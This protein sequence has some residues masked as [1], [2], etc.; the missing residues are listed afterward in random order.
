MQVRCVFGVASSVCLCA[1]ALATDPWA[2][3]VVSYT[4]GAGVGAGYDAPSTALGQPA[5]FTGVGVFPGAVTPFNAPFLNSEIVTVGR[6]GSLVVAFDEPVTNDAANP[7]G[8]DLLVFGNAFYQDAAYPSGV[9]AGLYGAAPTVEVSSDGVAWHSVNPA[10]VY[11]PSLGYRDLT[12]P[13]APDP[14]AVPTDFTRPVNPSFDANGR[15]FAELVAAYDGSGGGMGIDIGSLGLSSISYVRVRTS[16]NASLLPSID[17]FSDV[18]P[19]P[20]PGAGMLMV[21]GVATGVMRRRRR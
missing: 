7:Y 10:S 4:A 17:G 11:F 14:G 18:S 8:I 21:G 20:A 19:V 16:D 3:R 9:V 15:T 1:P 6:G 5:R 12:D 2:D 13:Y